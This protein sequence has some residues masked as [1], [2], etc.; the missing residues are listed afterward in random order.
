MKVSLQQVEDW[1][2]RSRAGG[3]RKPCERSAKL[4]V[5][6]WA[7]D[8]VVS[9]LAP[10]FPMQITCWCTALWPVHLVSVNRYDYLICH[11]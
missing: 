4:P 7:L 9:R 6:A 2:R 10:A 5:F 8:H 11:S 3:A 1:C